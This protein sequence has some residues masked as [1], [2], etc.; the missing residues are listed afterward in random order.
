MNMIHFMRNIATPNGEKRP[1]HD[2]KQ[3]G[4]LKIIYILGQQIE[5]RGRKPHRNSF[6]Y[7]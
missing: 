6:Y 4:Q 7:F 2:K 5:K 1:F 3:L